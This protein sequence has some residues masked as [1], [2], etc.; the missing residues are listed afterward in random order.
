MAVLMLEDLHGNIECVVFPRLYERT[1]E[2]F[3]EDAVLIVEGKVDTRSDRA[4]LVIERAEEF[5][6]PE[7]EAPP[8]P[9]MERKIEAPKNG[10]ANGKANGHAQVHEPAAAEPVS[11]VLKVRVPRNGDD[12]ACLRVL[13]Q[14][15]GLVE[16]NPGS[17]EIQLLLADR[18]GQGIELRGAEILVRHSDELEK[19]VRSLVGD[20]NVQATARVA[21]TSRGDQ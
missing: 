5:V 8:I 15:H 2:L 20:D 9:V 21:P 16:R 18:N 14:L 6:R 11:R 4:Q 10:H 12:N 3:R 19:Q 13:E 1:P 7:G 17:D